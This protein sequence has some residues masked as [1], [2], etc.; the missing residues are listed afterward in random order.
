MKAKLFMIGVV[1]F[2]MF[3]AGCGNAQKSTKALKGENEKRLANP[4]Q[5]FQDAKF[6]MFIHWGIYSVPARGIWVMHREKMTIKQYEPYATQFNP[7]EFD[8]AEWVRIAK[9]AGMKYITITSK[10]H[11]GFCMWDTKLTDWDIMDASPYKKD[12]LKMLA[13]ECKKQDMP[14]FF[15]YSQLDLHHPDYFPRGR[16]GEYS[17][18]PESGNWDNYIKY[19]NAQLAELCSGRYGKIAGIWF[20]GWWDQH[21]KDKSLWKGDP[22]MTS[23]DWH[24]QETYDLIHSLQPKAMIGNNHHVAPFPGEDF[25][26][27]ER[28]VPGSNPYSE[29]KGTSKLP[30]E[31][32]DTLN[33]SW[34]YN[35]SDKNFK[36][37]EEVVHYI[38]KAAGNNANLLLNVGPMPTGKIQP[39]F[40]ERLKEVGKWMK[41][42]GETIYGTRGGPVPPQD[43][44]YSTRKDNKV[45]LHIVKVKAGDEI[46]VPGLSAKNINSAKLF[47]TGKNVKHSQA[48]NA[49][50]IQLEASQIN[51]IDTIV[52]LDMKNIKI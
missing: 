51:N 27:F 14:L 45:Y 6:G 42:N 5:W 29:T 22:R 26:M 8:P 47:K 44:G 11:D 2:A 48:D 15:Y 28:G 12:I 18:R 16:T 24:L 30:L 32:C 13:D 52:V 4:P 10:H 38:V 50:K 46:V 21:P 20:D 37:T 31:T 25:Q 23:V 17:G 1:A 40:V 39:E 19:M 49:L 7:T 41:V 9:D 35:S 3:I 43:W 36:S 33:K 34:C